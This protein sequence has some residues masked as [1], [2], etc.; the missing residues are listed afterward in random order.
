M[1]YLPEISDVA[2]N[3]DNIVTPENNLSSSQVKLKERYIIDFNEPMQNLDTNGAK[4]YE[5]SDMIDKNKLLFALVCA[6]ETTPRHS[7]L[8]YIKSL[9][10]PHL[11]KLVEYGT[12][13]IP[14]TSDVSMVLI[15]QRPL[16]GR[17]IDDM[18]QP[19]RDNMNEVQTLWLQLIGSLS[20]LNTYG[21]T[22]R[23]IRLD[24]LFYLDETKKTVVLGDCAASFPAYY[25]PAVYETIETL[26]AQKSGRGNGSEKNDIYALAVLGLFLFQGKESGQDIPAPEMLAVKRKKGSYAALIGET[27]LSS[28]FANIF[29]NMLNDNFSARWS[30]SL[31]SG[32]LENSANNKISFT[33]SQE[34]TKKA[35]AFGGQKYYTAADVAYAIMQNPKEA[36]ELYNG[37]K[38]ID[39]VKNGLDNEDLALT[40]DKTVKAT[41]DNT[42]NHELSIAKICIYLAPSFPIKFGSL[43]LFPDALSKALYYANIH[44][45]DLNDYVR[46][47]SYDLLRLWFVNQEDTRTP[48][49]INEVKSCVQ[50]QAIGYGLDR[51]MYELDEDIPCL[52]PLLANDYICTPTR[53]L[54]VLNNSY[55]NGQDKPY[56]NHLIA[57]IRSRIGKKIDGL[58][59]DLNSKLPALEASAIL[60]LYTSLQNKF[61]PQ[62]L[63]KLAQWLSVFSMPLIKSYHNVR[64]Q[65]FLEKE[66]LKVNK[67]GRLYE[68]QELLESEEAR[69]KDSTEYNIARKTAAHLMSEKNM[70]VS[71]N[72]KWEEAARDMAIKGS[73]LLAVIVMLISFVINLFGVLKI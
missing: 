66:L 20:D 35:F 40:I 47:C 68:I 62:E 14:G 45:E 63:P 41:V 21:I 73:C 34:N 33:P 67:S 44:G 55:K 60:R 53:I 71:N 36:Y 13:T 61:G 12:V 23:S 42:P 22:H 52:S 7:I 72:N 2:E 46:L 32:I 38:L 28:S 54:R 9:N 30:L 5:A 4:A 25:Q 27:K 69:K 16:G 11:L 26:M 64:Y 50:S 18:S 24:N 58:L 70:L 49:I 65:K 29:R 19:F 43:S 57:Y 6:K 48:V 39:W 3:A 10:S 59:I 51:V 15:Y 37:G 56:D 31:M 8:P 1:S 17:V